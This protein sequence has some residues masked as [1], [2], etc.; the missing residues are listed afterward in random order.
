MATIK[1]FKGIRYNLSRVKDP[2]KV[3]TPPY[4]VIGSAEQEKLHQD[5]PYN[6]I[7]LEYAKSSP[8]DS[9]ADNRYTRAAAAYQKWLEDGILI[10]EENNCYYLYE[11]VFSYHSKEFK[12]RGVIAALKLTP[13][14]EK[15]VL[16]HERTM[17]GPK[18][19]RMELLKHLRTNV[20]PI[21]T[22]FP[23]PEQRL[24]QLFAEVDYAKPAVVV[25]E[26]SGQTHRLW[27]LDDPA[28]QDHLTAYLAPQPLLIAD[29]HHRYET[30]LSY[31][32]NE[33]SQGAPGSG[34]VLTIMVSMKDQGLL[35]LPT[36]RLLSG[37]DAEQIKGLFRIIELDFELIDRGDPRRLNRDTFLEEL[38][39]VSRKRGGFGLIT[40]GQASL[41]VPRDAAAA[42][43]LPVALLHER[44]LKPV[45]APGESS[46]VDKKML[47]YPHDLESALEAVLSRSADAAFILDPIAV[48]KVLDHAM[49]GK[50]MPQKSTFF[51]PK[52]PSGLVL[53]NMDLSY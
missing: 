16:P 36:H 49:E 6:I 26:D 22:L 23:D 29:G 40:A 46:E 24:D 47:S 32:Q 35:V 11:Q 13:Y 3:I 34:F 48:S 37:L 12:R 21:F 45:L 4:D 51:Y 17:A 5:S 39:E 31:C 2:G 43:N 27:L 1:P 44:I 14:S 41:L 28:L 19:D 20:S 30:A 53:Y 10:P 42:D 18:A 8:A 9:P 52:L 25:E 50:V 7:R 38:S 33:G 15:V